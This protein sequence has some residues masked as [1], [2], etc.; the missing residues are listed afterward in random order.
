MIPPWSPGP[1]LRCLPKL[2]SLQPPVLLG[3]TAGAEDDALGSFLL[4]GLDRVLGH[5]HVAD[6]IPLQPDV[7][8]LKQLR[9]SLATLQ[10]R[11]RP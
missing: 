9:I 8:E 2:Q 1:G 11:V 7:V 5:H 10:A 6:L 4:Q 3:V